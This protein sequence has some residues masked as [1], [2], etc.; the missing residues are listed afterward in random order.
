[1]GGQEGEWKTVGL[2]TR[3]QVL[4]RGKC[5]KDLKKSHISDKNIY[6]KT[7]QCHEDYAK[8]AE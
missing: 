7:R 4:K 3:N 6:I 1:M 5:V 8:K 2:K